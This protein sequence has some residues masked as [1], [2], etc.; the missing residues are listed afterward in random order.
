MILLFTDKSPG[1]RG[2]LITREQFLFVWITVMGWGIVVYTL[3]QWEKV[4]KGHFGPIH[5]MSD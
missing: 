4:G 3:I 1:F 2:F 5:G